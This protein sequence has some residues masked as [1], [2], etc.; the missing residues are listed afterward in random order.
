MRRDAQCHA[1]SDWP[2]RYGPW[3][4]AQRSDKGQAPTRWERHAED[5]WPHWRKKTILKWQHWSQKSFI[6]C[7]SRSISQCGLF[8]NGWLLHTGIHG[9]QISLEA[10][11][12][13]KGAGC[14]PGI[15]FVCVCRWWKDGDWPQ[16][17]V[18]TVA[19]CWYREYWP[20]GAVPVWIMF[21]PIFT[22]DTRLLLQAADKANLQN[23]LVKRFPM[24]H[25]EEEPHGVVFVLDG[26]SLL[27]RVPWPKSTSY[28]GL[29]Q[30]YAQFINSHFGS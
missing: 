3:W 26:G 18:P 1:D 20:R 13:E 22:F 14:Y 2:L 29:C 12:L 30:L 15:I 4:Q 6:W 25:I 27:Q 24:C 16:T 11:I 5:L 17:F 23:G 8:R 9:W 28:T 21:V 19:G 7:G 10:Q